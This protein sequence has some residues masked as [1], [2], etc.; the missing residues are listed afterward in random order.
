MDGRAAGGAAHRSTLE[1]FVP[2]PGFESEARRANRL[3]TGFERE[4]LSGLR[5][6]GGDAS[7]PE[8]LGRVAYPSRRS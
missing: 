2:P 7:H 1:S 5:G 8:D 4:R 3:D 6:D